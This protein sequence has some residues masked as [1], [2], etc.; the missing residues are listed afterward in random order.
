M[1]SKLA[2]TLS[3]L[4][5][6]ENGA[7]QI[8]NFIA[9]SYSAPAYDPNDSEKN[10]SQGLVLPLDALSQMSRLLS[11]LPSQ[12]SPETYFHGLAPQLWDLLEAKNDPEMRKAS[13]YIIGSGIL[14]KKA[15]GAP[16]KIGWKLFAEPLLKAINPDDQADRRAGTILTDENKLA[17]AL[18]RLATIVMS[19][20]NPGLA[21]R[22]L[23]PIILPLWGLFN[24]SKRGVSNSTWVNTTS[25]ILKT[26]LRICA[27]KE[28]FLLIANNLL[29]EG[30]SH[31]MFGHGSEGGIQINSREIKEEDPFKMLQS[32]PLIDE[33]ISNFLYLLDISDTE[34]ESIITIF[35]AATKRWL[36][37]EDGADAR[38]SVLGADKESD[39][40]KMLV[41]AKLSQAMLGRFKSQIMK[42]PFRIIELLEQLLKEHLK[43]VEV[44]KKSLYQ[45]GIPESK[46]LITL[47]SESKL[48]NGRGSTVDNA[49]DE[50]SADMVVVA[51]SLLDTIVSAET[52]ISKPDTK[53][54]LQRLLP[55]LESLIAPS[56]NTKSPSISALAGKLARAIRE[57]NIP[58]PQSN[59]NSNEISNDQTLYHTALE[60]LSSE[61]AP[62]RVEGLS[63]IQEL[64]ASHSP[65]VSL[66]AVTLLFI[67]SVLTDPDSFVHLA[68]IRTLVML[69]EQDPRLMS[70]LL[71]DTFIDPNEEEGHRLE[72]RLAVGETLGSI[73]QAIPYD[74]DAGRTGD[75]EKT[76]GWKIRGGHKETQIRCDYATR[77]A[78]LRIIVLALLRVSGR[79]GKR[80]KSK[81]ARERKAKLAFLKQKEAEKAWGGE[82]PQ[83]AQIEEED[84]KDTDM[85]EGAR[86]GTTTILQNILHGWEDTGLEED[87]RLRASALSILGQVLELHLAAVDEAGVLASSV[88]LALQVVRSPAEAGPERALIRRAAVLA[89]A[90]L[91]RGL[92]RVYESKEGYR[93]RGDWQV[94]GEALA[95][96]VDWQGVEDTLRW[97]SDVDE[98]EMVKG[99]ART[100]I[101]GLEAWKVKRVLGVSGNGVVDGIDKMVGGDVGVRFGFGSNGT[102][103]HFDG[104]GSEN[105]KLAGLHISPELWANN[106]DNEDQSRKKP[107]VEEVE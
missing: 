19:H 83:L 42:E 99:H 29:W 60:N 74:Y 101:E 54:S 66:P 76:E 68:G 6:R 105:M 86:Q 52:T 93:T 58:S 82:V 97:V 17:C 24:Y 37:P 47:I 46:K 12:M 98:D 77:T 79:R 90:M 43:S 89:L 48:P 4:P 41:F 34:P 8:I 87:V 64:I 44:K 69:A 14:G 33:C 53:E 61:L 71:S 95:K 59:S 80:V 100:A 39:P 13:G 30:P 49:I 15:L 51:L 92:D 20:P 38:R 75:G 103:S 2:S 65:V 1:R 81:K 94:D 57:P 45:P 10:A 91:V 85:E 50:E 88:D 32:M 40:F 25:E 36:L 84:D 11:S 7:R 22:L 28:H 27:R 9:A 16:G 18:R 104:K 73:V 31:W 56:S 21:R 3:L 107:M 26:F 102:N 35:L 78:V 62:I 55:L 5:L 96:S 72:V 67:Q 106:K 23:Q 63:T 70:R